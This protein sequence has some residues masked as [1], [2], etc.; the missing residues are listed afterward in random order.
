MCV[1]LKIARI[2]LQIDQVTR[3]I[4]PTQKSFLYNFI[5]LILSTYHWF[6]RQTYLWMFKRD[7][8]ESSYNHDSNVARYLGIF[9]EGPRSFVFRQPCLASSRDYDLLFCFVLPRY[10]ACI[11]WPFFRQ[12]SGDTLRGVCVQCVSFYMHLLSLI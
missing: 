6:G 10:L 1:C 3:S 7:G 4:L 5:P 12:P 2:V 9:S 8:R 11:P